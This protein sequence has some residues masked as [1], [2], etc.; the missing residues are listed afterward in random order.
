MHVTHV[1]HVVG[2]RRRPLRWTGVTT[3]KRLW[4]RK[5]GRL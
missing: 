1:S 4:C 3:R 2:Q 5:A